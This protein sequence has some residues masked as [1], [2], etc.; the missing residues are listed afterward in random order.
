VMTFY[1][2][3]LSIENHVISKL[4]IRSALLR[5]TKWLVLYPNEAVSAH[6]Q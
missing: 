2:L 1:W 5:D 6:M 3:F 4:Q